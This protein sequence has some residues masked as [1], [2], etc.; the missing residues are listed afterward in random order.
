MAVEEVNHAIHSIVAIILAVDG[1]SNGFEEDAIAAHGK[2]S[3]VSVVNASV[4]FVFSAG[5]RD[6]G[7]GV[8]SSHV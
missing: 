8:R 5:T 2:I 4:H 6:A 7:E 1:A 3:R